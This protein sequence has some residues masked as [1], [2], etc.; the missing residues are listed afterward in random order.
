MDKRESDDGENEECARKVMEVPELYR[1]TTA[2]R[3]SMLPN[4]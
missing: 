2:E 4:T 1:D 3:S